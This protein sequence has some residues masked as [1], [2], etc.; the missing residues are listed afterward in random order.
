MD[1]L[2]SA[3]NLQKAATARKIEAVRNAVTSLQRSNR[4]ITIASIAGEASVSRSFLYQNLAAREIVTE[5]RSTSARSSFPEDQSSSMWRARA[6]NAES[7]I[8]ICEQEISK[9]RQL[10]ARLMGES[11]DLKDRLPS[12]GLEILQSELSRL[13]HEAS[14]LRFQLITQKQSLEAA[15]ANNSE[16]RRQIASMPGHHS[17]SLQRP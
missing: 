10:I 12:E 15:R 4:S 16:L 1:N 2:S 8:K 3:H 13:R 6:I 14:E 7:R 5:G 17:P 9:Q 11:A